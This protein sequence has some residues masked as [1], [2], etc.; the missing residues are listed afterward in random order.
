MSSISS[1]N[2]IEFEHLEQRRLLHGSPA[3]SI[4]DVA[5]TEDQGG[6]TALVFTVSLS[7]PSSRRVSVNFATENGSAVAGE[8]YAHTSGTLSFAPG[9]K[10]RTVTVLVNG[11]TTVEGDETFS[12]KLRNARNAFIAD[13]RG[14]GTIVNDDILPPPPPVD[15]P[16]YEPPADPGYYDYGDWYYGYPYNGWGEYP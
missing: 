5:L 2:R 6:A 15:P 8:D 10:A 16:P 11:D 14:V 1:T 9:Q 13:D 4:D 7:K 12:V 3:I